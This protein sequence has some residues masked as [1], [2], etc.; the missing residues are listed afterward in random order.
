[1][2]AEQVSVVALEAGR[3]ELLELQLLKVVREIVEEVAD[4]RVVAVA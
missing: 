2:R 4:A 3:D 1:M